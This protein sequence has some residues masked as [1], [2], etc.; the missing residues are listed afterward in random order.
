MEFLKK[1]L[2]NYLAMAVALAMLVGTIALAARGSVT[3]QG[4]VLPNSGE[5]TVDV[6]FDG[7][8]M[9][10]P[11]FVPS[12]HIAFEDGIPA[13]TIAFEDVEG[14]MF[15]TTY[16][17]Q[18]YYDDEPTVR[19]QEEG[20]VT[21][22]FSPSELST[23]IVPIL[24]GI[25]QTG[26]SLPAT[27]TFDLLQFGGDEDDVDI[28]DGG[29]N[30]DENGQPEQTQPTNPHDIEDGF[31]LINLTMVQADG[32][33]P[34]ALHNSLVNP[35][36]LFV[37]QGN[38][39][40]TVE[41]N[42]VVRVWAEPAGVPSI[43][44]PGGVSPTG[45]SFRF[46]LSKL[47]M[48]RL[49]VYVEEMGP[50]MI[51]VIFLNFDLTDIEPTEPDPIDDTALRNTLNAAGSTR[52]AVDEFLA[53]HDHA[54]ELLERADASQGELDA[55]KAR[56]S[57]ANTALNPPHTGYSGSSGFDSGS[58]WSLGNGG[59][60]NGLYLI[61][62][63]ALHAAEA[64]LSM[65]DEAIRAPGELNVVNGKM[66][67]TLA[68]W[69]DPYAMEYMDLNDEFIS[70]PFMQRNVV[71]HNERGARLSADDAE[72]NVVFR[73]PVDNLTENIRMR[74][75]FGAGSY[76]EFR[77]Q[78]NPDSLQRIGLGT[79]ELENDESFGVHT[80]TM[81]TDI[82]MP[83]M[84]FPAAAE[85]FFKE[86]V[87]ITSENGAYTVTAVMHGTEAISM[88]SVDE[89]RLIL[90]NKG[91]VPLDTVLNGEAD[92]LTFT[93]TV[94]SLDERVLM[95][96]CPSGYTRGDMFFRMVFNQATKQNVDPN[97]P[98]DNSFTMKVRAL[99]LNSDKASVL[100]SSLAGT[101]TIA[102][103]GS[104]YRVSVPMNISDNSILGESYDD[105][106]I[107]QPNGEP[108]SVGRV[109]DT[110][111][112]IVTITFYTDTLDYV[113]MNIP[114]PRFPGVRVEYR[115]VFDQ[116]TRQ[117]IGKAEQASG[118]VMDVRALMINSDSPSALGAEYNGTAFVANVGG[119]YRVSVPIKDGETAEAHENRGYEQ[120]RH[121]NGEAVAAER[122]SAIV[123]Y[124]DTLDYVIVNVPTPGMAGTRVD[125]RLVFDQNTRRAG[126]SL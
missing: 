63:R 103:V 49:G 2:R 97:A 32:V 62:A 61:G 71:Q 66:Y 59:L 93:F 76:Q 17:S 13:V 35:A 42:G 53:A 115:L 36:K 54:Q 52:E 72:I 25:D 58:G 104:R 8:F 48:P 51:Q 96:I 109:Y 86:A 23:G 89:V 15:D 111:A 119:R 81:E 69:S 7:S 120:L 79:S 95:E 19:T 64:Q 90:P 16:I 68:W 80:F 38:M 124:T 41:I 45:N 39:T 9:V 20:Y 60:A 123:F 11:M 4:A 85:R 47:S 67:L 106:K 27:L 73:I 94:D 30:D 101:A 92:T 21:F 107:R 126:I 116:N 117:N 112:G 87:T 77:L 18:V 74:I 29:D 46:P 100:G 5:Y 40:V 99:M 108:V 12:A 57:A 118:F 34:S 1:T 114:T 110:S 50:S 31:Y 84:D 37:Y 102:E 82:L 10:A 105:T 33:T 70:I 22:T 43:D 125:Y 3:V 78:L 75:Y 44:T 24:V 91:S 122:Y 121:P 55:A 14:H 83:D 88:N 56:L 6:T 65:A 28:D 113:V 26:M 98:A